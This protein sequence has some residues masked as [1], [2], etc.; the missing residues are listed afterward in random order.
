MVIEPGEVHTLK[1]IDIRLRAS[2]NSFFNASF[3]VV[4]T[5]IT[6][7]RDVEAAFGRRVDNQGAP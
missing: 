6:I 1:D 5:S 3:R 4:K 2:L 7:F